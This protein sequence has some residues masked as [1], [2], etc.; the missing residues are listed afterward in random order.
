MLIRIGATI[1]LK[2]KINQ[3]LNIFEPITFHTDNDQLPLIAAIADKN[4]SGAE[5]PKAITVNHISNAETF[6][7]FAIL[8]LVFTRWLAENAKTNNHNHNKINAD[9]IVEKK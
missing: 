1:A 9:I 6:K 8:T 7:Y 4:N 2:P 5:V 3:R